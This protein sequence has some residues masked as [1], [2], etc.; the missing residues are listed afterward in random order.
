LP[1]PNIRCKDGLPIFNIFTN[2]FKKVRK[3]RKFKNTY[4]AGDTNKHTC[5][6]MADILKPEIQKIQLKDKK[7]LQST[8]IL[9]NRS[10]AKYGSLMRKK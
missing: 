9:Q 5:E 10:G 3:F 8:S 1:D 4:M 6:F 2:D 7:F